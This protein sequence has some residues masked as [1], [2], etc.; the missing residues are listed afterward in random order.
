MD[1]S[2]LIGSNRLWNVRVMGNA[3]DEPAASTEKKA[4]GILDV[5]QP[6]AA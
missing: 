1:G 3:G 6:G 4:K 5:L 2:A